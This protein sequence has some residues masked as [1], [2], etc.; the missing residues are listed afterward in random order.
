MI[1]SSLIDSSVIDSSLVVVSL[2]R[3][4]DNARRSSLRICCKTKEGLIVFTLLI[5][6]TCKSARCWSRISWKRY[7]AIVRKTAVRRIVRQEE[8][9]MVMSFHCV[10]CCDV[11][12]SGEVWRG[13]ET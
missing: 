9:G 1:D 4:D 7:P 8:P 13:L 10:V 6:G 11:V 2:F 3:N 12:W 5:L